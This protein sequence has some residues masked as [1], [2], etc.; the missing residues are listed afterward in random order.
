M[1]KK[2]KKIFTNGRVL[3]LMFFLLLALIAI[4]P[5]PLNEGVSIRSVFTNSSASLAGISNPKPAATP[6]SREVIKTINNRP[7]TNLEDYNNMINSFG[8]GRS[9]I[10]VTN[11]DT[12]R[13]V[14]KEIIMHNDFF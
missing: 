5:N 6:M 9:V 7:I 11:Q 10:I 13:L 8:P 14:T 2:V 3:V 12:Y 1:A 4:H